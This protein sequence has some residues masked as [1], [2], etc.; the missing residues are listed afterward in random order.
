MI[1][2]TSR[3]RS[4]NPVQLGLVLGLI[5]AVLSFLAA[6]LLLIYGSIVP[7]G[8]GSY[9]MVGRGG[10]LSLILFPICYFIV[11]F[12]VGSIVG[13]L[14]NLVAGWTGGVEISLESTPG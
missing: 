9:F 12:I 8:M 14:Y 6:V 5:Y 13:A 4:I 10:F 11:G 3:L 2:T 7:F 1:R